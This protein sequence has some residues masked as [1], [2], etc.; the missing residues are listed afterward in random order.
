M[1]IDEARDPA[2]RPRPLRDRPVELDEPEAAR[3]VAGAHRVVRV[4]ADRLRPARE[5]APGPDP[6]VLRRDGG[7]DVL[8]DRAEAALQL[9]DPEPA[10]PV[11]EPERAREVEQ[12]PPPLDVAVHEG[13]V[14]RVEGR[15]VVVDLGRHRPVVRLALPVVRGREEPHARGVARRHAVRGAALRR[16][17]P[18]AQVLAEL[19]GDELLPVDVVGVREDRA[20][21]V[22]LDLLP[23]RVAAVPRR[24]ERVER[25]VLLRQ[26]Q[27]K[28]RHGAPAEAELRARDVGRV[29]PVDDVGLAPEV[30]AE[31]GGARAGAPRHRLVEGEVGL[32]HAGVVQAVAR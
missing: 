29:R 31:E 9:A 22:R 10:P 19:V 27:A 1:A 24:V 3:L 28:A 5:G 17:V 13:R 21:P 8:R 11:R 18:R 16:L 6:Q 20:E 26:P 2:R 7:A 30:E 12:R 25:A 32:A 4:G 14:L 15:P 23:R